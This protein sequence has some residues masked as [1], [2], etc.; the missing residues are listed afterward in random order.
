MTS[1]STCGGRSGETRS[2][3][4][5]DSLATAL[6]GSGGRREAGGLPGPGPP[7]GKSRPPGSF[8]E[9]RPERGGPGHLRGGCGGLV[10]TR[11]HPND[12]PRSAEE[13]GGSALATEEGGPRRR[14]P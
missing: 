9:W 12:S 7:R 8:D 13:G 14:R 11:L 4:G 3:S 10:Q 6:L 1:R 5:T 2:S